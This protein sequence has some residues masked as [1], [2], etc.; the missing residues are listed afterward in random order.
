MNDE[1]LNMTRSSRTDETAEDIFAR[2]Q[3]RRALAMNGN[4]TER[5]ALRQEGA[6]SETRPTAVAGELLADIPPECLGV[7]RK[8]SSPTARD[9]AIVPGPTPHELRSEERRVGKECRS[10]WSP[11]H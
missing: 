7:P 5:G 9:V 8:A 1:Q 4:N 6:S 11:Y 10:R 3:R 2:I